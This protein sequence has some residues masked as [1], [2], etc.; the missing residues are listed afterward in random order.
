MNKN[1]DII[2][3]LCN[4]S[5]IMLSS[6]CTAG[7]VSTIILLLFCPWNFQHPNK[8]KSPFGI[9]LVKQALSFFKN[10]ILLILVQVA[11]CN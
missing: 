5:K 2:F 7:L 9:I 11:K 1:V 10:V 8:I 3:Y 4:P 6:I